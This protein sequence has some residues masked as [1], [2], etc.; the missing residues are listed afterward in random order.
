MGA[1]RICWAVH[2]GRA[3]IRNQALGLA[4]AVAR[5]A[6]VRVE[7]RVL[8]E[9]GWAERLGFAH[10]P[11][12]NPP[13]PNLW[14]ACGRRSVKRSISMRRWAKGQTYVVQ[15]QHPRRDPSLFDLV[16]AP[17]HDRLQGSNV[18]SMIGSPNRIDAEALVT[19]EW[20][21]GAEL[22]RLRRPRAAV[23]V[24]GASK[25]HRMDQASLAALSDALSALR[26]QGVSLM[27]SS[28]RRTPQDAR[29]IIAAHKGEKNVWVYDG[30]GDNPYF[31]FLAAAD[32]V[33]VTRDSVN[34]LT[35]AATAGKPV[36]TLPVAGRDGKFSRLYETLQA[37]NSIRPFAGR[38]ET[39]QTTP[40][41]ETARLAREIVDRSSIL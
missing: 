41:A 7:E 30:E 25:R 5:I 15:I 28:S 35:E 31:A 33:L 38:L 20:R 4:E 32:V 39:W 26:A 21:F 29:T 3:G 13:W 27:I 16:V 6:D 37:R 24:G 12:L 34:M 1:T 18:I 40:L 36:L 14:I 2:D 11:T 9:A 17:E 22:A 23:L 19:A 10:D 8:G